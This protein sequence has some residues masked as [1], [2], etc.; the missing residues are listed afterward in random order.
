MHAVAFSPFHDGLLATAADDCRVMLFDVAAGAE[1]TSTD[2]RGGC[3]R[4]A[5]I[6]STRAEESRVRLEERRPQVASGSKEGADEV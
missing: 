5:A 6:S 1:A 3:P 2:A 4:Y